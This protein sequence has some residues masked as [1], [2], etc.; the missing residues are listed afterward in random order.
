MSRVWGLNVLTKS[1]KGNQQI[2]S[3]HP[4][5]LPLF[6]SWH[7]HKT[8]GAGK[9]SQNLYQ[10]CISLLPFSFL[11]HVISSFRASHLSFRPLHD[12]MT[13][14]WC[15]LKIEKGED[16][17]DTFSHEK[18]KEMQ[19]EVSYN[20]FFLKSTTQWWWRGHFKSLD[21]HPD[22]SSHSSISDDCIT[23]SIKIFK[24]LKFC[25]DASKI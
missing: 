10:K 16:T 8:Q 3:F 13:W 17:R 19:I 6:S 23:C 12:D 9:M 2:P 7:N 25:S 14:G 21:D 4:F 11:S 24:A 5:C 1:W 15:V 22:D 18:W 20:Y